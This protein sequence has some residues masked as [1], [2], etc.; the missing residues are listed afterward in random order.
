MFSSRIATIRGTLEQVRRIPGALDWFGAQKHQF[1]LRPPLAESELA[2]FERRHGVVLPGDY[3]SFLLLAGDGGAGPYY[4][5]EPLSNW[6]QWFEEEGEQP[7][8]LSSPCPLT[9]SEA[10]RRAWTAA[11]ERD[12]RRARGIVNPGA[13]PSRSWETFLA[14]AWPE[15][16]RGTIHLC[17]QGCTYSARLIVSGEAR[18]RIVYLDAQLWYPPYFA[19][20]PGFLDWYE[21]WLEE[22]AA[23]R[24]PDWYGFHNSAFAGPPDT[25]APPSG[26]LH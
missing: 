10:V 4:G 7:G 23:G 20:G 22:A 16:G 18:G 5:I 3:R 26:R 21:R 25:P 1:R 13:A 11:M 19:A 9:G 14:P 6:D 17:D 15:W 8:F 24:P 12:A 2:A